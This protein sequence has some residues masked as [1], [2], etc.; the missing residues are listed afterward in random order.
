M[1]VEAVTIGLA[2]ADHDVHVIAHGL[3][4]LYIGK[5]GAAGLGGKLQ[6]AVGGGQPG[7]VL[8]HLDALVGAEPD[9]FDLLHGAVGLD[10]GQEFIHLVP[11]Q[12]ALLR[13][14]KGKSVAVLRQVV[15]EI[16]HPRV[17]GAQHPGH[18]LIHEEGGDFPLFHRQ[19]H[20]GIGGVILFL[21]VV[22]VGI[23][24]LVKGGAGHDSDGLPI[25]LTDIRDGS[26]LFLRPGA[27]HQLHQ[28][29]NHQSQISQ[30][31]LHPSHSFSSCCRS[32]IPSL[33]AESISS[34]CRQEMP[35][36][37]IKKSRITLPAT[38]RP[39]ASAGMPS[40][41]SRTV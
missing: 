4:I 20:V 32:S 5:G 17:L 37:V 11:K 6:G 34:D 36:E 10:L 38:A 30:A 40:C 35:Q 19:R 26:A 24:M 27:A 39:T 13:L 25:Q 14:G 28:Q 16:G 15:L 7:P 2:E 3:S 1:E 22:D 12:G 29:K 21:C 9:G 23:G 33:L 8:H 41:V 18:G 31:F